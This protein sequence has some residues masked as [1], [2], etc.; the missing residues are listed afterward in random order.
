MVA[1][2]LTAGIL[3]GCEKARSQRVTQRT[4]ARH[5]HTFEA[6]AA[7]FELNQ[8]QWDRRIK[9]R[10]AA[11]HGL[12][13]TDNGFVIALS[14]PANPDST[15]SSPQVRK[16]SD[17][18][19][20]RASKVSRSF[21]RLEFIADNPHPK[22]RGEK[23]LPG[24]S[25][26]FIGSDPTKWRRNVSRFAMVRY[27]DIYP[28]IDLMVHEKTTGATEY[29]L[30]AAPGAD[31]A[32]IQLGIRGARNAKLNRAGELLIDT[33]DGSMVGPAPVIYQE[34]DGVRKSVAGGY[35]LND[36]FR[37][38]FKVGA[39]D[40][41]RPLIID[42]TI[43]PT[44]STF[45]GGSGVD[46]GVGIAVDT[47][48]NT[49]ISGNTTSADFP[50]TTGAFQTTSNNADVTFDTDVFISKLSADGTALIYSTYLSG[51][52]GAQA[53]AVAVDAAGSAYVVGLQGG[54]GF[55]YTPNSY[56]GPGLG[57][58]FV[59][60]LSPDGSQLVYSASLGSNGN[61]GIAVD[62]T[63]NA[64]VASM[65]G[66]GAPQAFKL[67]ADGSGLVYQATLP[68]PR[69][70]RGSPFQGSA[71]AIVVDSVGEAF[72]AGDYDNV[73]PGG[74]GGPPCPASMVW[75]LS[76]DAS[77]VIY[78][79]AEAAAC[80]GSQFPTGPATS[81]GVDNS[82]NAYAVTGGFITKLD[83]T[84]AP[85]AYQNSSQ[86]D[87][88]GINAIAVDPSGITCVTG[89]T[90]ATSFSGT[91]TPDAFQSQ[92]PGQQS[93]FI[94]R[95]DAGGSVFLY[96]TYFGGINTDSGNAIAIDAQGNGYI[97]GYTTSSDFPHTGGA[98][99]GSL[100]GNQNA[101][102]AKFEFPVLATPTPTPAVPPTSVPQKATPTPAKTSA[103]LPTRT[104]DGTASATV[105]Q[106][107]STSPT[108]TDTPT[109]APTV[110]MMPT[111]TSTPTPT[112]MP[113]ATPQSSPVTPPT[114]VGPR[115]LS[116]SP[117]AASF[118]AVRV[119]RSR[120]G[121]IRVRN[122]DKSP[123]TIEQMQ[124]SG[125]TDFTW[126]TNCGQMIAPGAR[127]EIHAT[128]SPT[129]TQF[130][131]GSISVSSNTPMSPLRVLLK[132]R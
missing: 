84:G 124:Y 45:L 109:P 17:V 34:I 78:S 76:A 79:H 103:P 35:V 11:F 108:R 47:S 107:P 98:L 114:P 41:S 62:S 87:L 59:T 25:N 16:Q 71:N 51:A 70:L 40:N 44:Y 96:S 28:G 86:S 132:G 12:F 94:S 116:V 101:F 92:L 50:V 18:A 38:G 10:S 5:P 102:V 131:S 19:A 110:T 117:R 97:T 125:S 64:Y 63:G 130:V 52:G 55:P 68:T 61:N 100:N 74:P 48:G 113:T 60:K 89:A 73:G 37:V 88:R 129:T 24:K 43:L 122:V 7:G 23:L 115:S 67:N 66:S 42:P 104:P 80:E 81:I 77:A 46:T 13:L 2:F 106:T 112:L 22:I 120:V 3:C 111:L 27:S 95:L 57:E 121:T 33:P 105:T 49:Y 123:V 128:F 6:L 29:D 30:V 93:A 82:G 118:G 85:I 99:Q 126:N 69:D 58:D 9:F 4:D 65:S 21:L 1:L 127:C 91:T 83:P 119:G 26:Y 39:Y 14:G 8:G 36:S 54:G 32:R 72:I 90:S 53:G 75:K 20:K 15:K 56:Q 31:P